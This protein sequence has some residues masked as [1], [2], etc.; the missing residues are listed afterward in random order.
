[1][2]AIPD[3]G[4][5]DEDGHAR[6]PPGEAME[7]TLGPLIAGTPVNGARRLSLMARAEQI[8]RRLGARLCWIR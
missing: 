8:A 2:I 6:A 4:P 1:V 3:D 5:L 7:L